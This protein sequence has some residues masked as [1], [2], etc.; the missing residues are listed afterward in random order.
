MKIAS[1]IIAYIV[2]NLILFLG[3]IV[4]LYYFPAKKEEDTFYYQIRKLGL[5]QRIFI[6]AILESMAR[7]MRSILKILKKWRL[8][9]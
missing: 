4:Y 9:K 7:I 8:I 3:G 5:A 2:L 6:N 1:A